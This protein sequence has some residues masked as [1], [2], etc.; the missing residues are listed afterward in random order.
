MIEKFDVSREHGIPIAAMAGDRL[1]LDTGSP[2]S[3]AR[4]GSIILGGCGHSVPIDCWAGSPDSLSE[5]L[6]E[7]VD[8]LLGCDLLA[9]RILDLDCPAGRAHVISGDTSPA[10]PCWLANAIPLSFSTTMG[11]PVAQLSVN[12]RQALAAVDTGAAICFAV[13]SLLTDTPVIGRHH[14]FHPA[15]GR[16]ETDVHLASVGL[17]GGTSPVDVPAAAAPPALAPLLAG[18]ELQA[19]LGGD[20]LMGSEILFDFRAESGVVLLSSP[21]IPEARIIAMSS[22][23]P[24]LLRR[25]Q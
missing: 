4:N 20:L 17:G 19:I 12:G 10:T 24:F 22:D 3:F 21:P 14:E 8:G 15:I 7:A 18:L 25:F 1:I 9:G 2:T 16:F 6:G 13:P 5:L 23:H 11:V